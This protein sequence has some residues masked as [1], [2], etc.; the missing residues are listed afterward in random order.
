[1]ALMFVEWAMFTPLAIIPLAAFTMFT[2]AAFCSALPASVT[3]LF[4]VVLIV[5]PSTA[6]LVAEAS[7]RLTAPSTLSV[8]LVLLTEVLDFML[9]LLATRL[10]TVLVAKLFEALT[11]LDVA[12]LLEDVTFLVFELLEDS[13]NDEDLLAEADSVS[14]LALLDDELVAKLSL[15]ACE[16][17]LLV[18]KLSLAACEADLSVAK[19]SLAA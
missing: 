19:L 16:A 13:P 9:E 18:A 15:A 6:M 3:L 4:E 5:E 7:S 14:V 12:K 11:S 10:A 1:M 8:T 2:P 17:V